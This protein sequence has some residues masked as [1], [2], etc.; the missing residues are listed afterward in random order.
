MTNGV[1]QTDTVL[2]RILRQTAIDVEERKAAVPAERLDKQIK[3]QDREVLSLAR[4]LDRDTIAVIAEFKRG[5]PSRGRFPVAIDPA[6]VAHAYCTGG[7]SAIS[8]LTDGPF[9]HGSKDD[10]E[11]VASVAHAET[12][13]IPV[14]RKDFTIDRYQLLESRAW[15]ADVVLLIVAALD[16]AL[17]GSLYRGAKDLGLSVLVEVHDEAEMER[18]LRLE[19]EVIGVNNRNLHTFEVDLRVT[20]RLAAMVAGTTLLVSESGIF[21]PDQVAQVGSAGAAAVLV[22][23]SLILQDDR[24]A[25]VR[26]LAGVPR[27]S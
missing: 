6:D 24:V 21:T 26:A 5:S 11:A 18:A 23:E 16:D 13:A 20:E 7:A 12:Q 25:A 19:P 15:G 4:A 1:L 22:G 3:R 2:D 9:F 27:V 17:L 8:C 14:L 10:L